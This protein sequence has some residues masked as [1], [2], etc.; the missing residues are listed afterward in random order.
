ME[1][2]LDTNAYSDWLRSGI[3]NRE[4]S[5][6]SKILIPVIVLGELYHGFHKGT[7]FQKNET[8]LMD[9]LSV[10]TALSILV[11]LV[12]LALGAIGCAVGSFI[13]TGWFGFLMTLTWW[14]GRLLGCWGATP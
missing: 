3:W 4:I 10:L 2:V 6:A 5:Q 9:I 13:D 1:V 8:I 7:R 12:M 11:G 14:T